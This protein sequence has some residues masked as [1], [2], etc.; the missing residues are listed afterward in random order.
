MKT[1]ERAGNLRMLPSD[2]P[3]WQTAAVCN[4]ESDPAVVQN[5]FLARSEAQ[6][7]AWMAHNGILL[8]RVALGLVFLWFGALKFFPG[9][10]EAEDLAKR[11][12]IKLT[13]G[14][15][16]SALCVYGLATW[17][18]TIGLGLLTGRF[19]RG[20]LIL[21][22][23]QLSGTFLPLFFFPAETWRH[24]PYAP[25]FEGQYII[26]NLVLISA[27]IIVGSTMAGG[28][29]IAD[30]KVAR[31]AERMEAVRTRFGRR[32]ELLSKFRSPARR[33]AASELVVS[34]NAAGNS[35][36]TARRLG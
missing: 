7:S 2:L 11:T 23:L 8:T 24:F 4:D 30:P 28:K 36:V 19:L 34:E 29:I 17:E 6:A 26:K 22:L 9:T 12:L 5:G 16:P 25:T 15:L 13:S 27:A 18:C 31:F 3:E 33:S 32:F 20:T 1:K 10:S 35:A 14:Y 21:L